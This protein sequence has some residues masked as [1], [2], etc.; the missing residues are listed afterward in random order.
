MKLGDIL[1]AKN[2]AGLVPSV[3][4]DVEFKIVG[5]GKGS[6]DPVTATAKATLAVINEEERAEAIREATLAV[7]KLFSDVAAPQESMGFETAI[8]VLAKALRDRDDPRG[9]FANV[10]ELRRALV[11]PVATRL[12]SEYLAYQAEEFPDTVDN[13]TFNR[14][15]EDAKK[16]SVVDLLFTYGSSLILRVMPTLAIASGAP[17]EPS[18]SATTPA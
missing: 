7:A 2:Q 16:K 8:H 14:L 11:Q 1:S 4:R 5:K 18:T 6:G 3:T 13:A 10:D 12:Y 9:H 17:R 15:L